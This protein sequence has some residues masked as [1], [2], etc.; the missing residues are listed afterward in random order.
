MPN[1][2][3][4]SWILL[5]LINASIAGNVYHICILYSMIYFKNKVS[6]KK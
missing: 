2:L 1:L 4:L 6:K 5:G 3:A